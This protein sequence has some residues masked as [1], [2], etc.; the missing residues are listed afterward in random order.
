MKENLKPN[1][2]D[3]TKSSIGSLK[4]SLKINSNVKMRIPLEM[5]KEN[6][7]NTEANK[8]NIENSLEV[9]KHV[10]NNQTSNNSLYYINELKHNSSRLQHN[11]TSNIESKSSRISAFSDK[12][13]KISLNRKKKS[14]SNEKW[15]KINIFDF[16]KYKA[17]HCNKGNEFIFSFECFKYR[18]ESKQSKNYISRF[19]LI[20]INRLM[21]YKSK[22]DLLSSLPEYETIR[23][24]SIESVNRVLLA[25]Q[26][27]NSKVL[28]Y[29]LIKLK[30]DSS[31][32]NK[33]RINSQNLNKDYS[34][35]VNASQNNNNTSI[36]NRKENER[37][38]FIINN[39]S[40]LLEISTTDYLESKKMKNS[41]INM[42]INIDT[43]KTSKHDNILEEEQCLIIGV[44]SEQDADRI[45]A[46]LNYLL[47]NALIFN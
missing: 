45:T 43:L 46:I 7:Q 39:T 44:E 10:N 17:I 2:V 33:I 42:S 14:N 23:I 29:I 26:K 22:E 31:N 34:S 8:I 41:K 28:N 21:F 36:I 3:I 47:D 1:K 16:I 35:L 37:F 24:S 19:C 30:S 40:G 27:N 5:I 6:E 18:K 25:R 12:V 32:L 9:I 13:R 20:H 4:A 38:S 15:K 11:T